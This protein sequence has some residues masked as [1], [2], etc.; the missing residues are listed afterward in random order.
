MSHV[1]LVTTAMVST[2]A[3]TARAESLVVDADS[4]VAW[5]RC[6]ALGCPARGACVRSLAVTMDKHVV[7]EARAI[8]A[9]R[10]WPDD[11]PLG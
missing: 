6:V 8:R 11:V 9:R 4:S 7:P 10:V 2:V 1:A 5:G 3:W